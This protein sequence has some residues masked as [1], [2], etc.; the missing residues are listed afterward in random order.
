MKK[1]IPYK[2]S[3]ELLAR[4]EDIFRVYRDHA[5]CYARQSR[6]RMAPIGRCR[7]KPRVNAKARNERL[8]R[9]WRFMECERGLSH[10]VL[11]PERLPE[12]LQR[13]TLVIESAALC[14]AFSV[15]VSRE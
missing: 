3:P 4:R 9:I 1:P 7:P 14:L 15:R 6:C 8:V 11:S 10:V 5:T 2:V 13:A 12:P